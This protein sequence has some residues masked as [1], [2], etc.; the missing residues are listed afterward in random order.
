MLE[1]AGAIPP[2]AFYGRIV[3]SRCPVRSGTTSSRPPDQRTHSA[4][5]QQQQTAARVIA[6]RGEVGREEVLR[7]KKIFF[8]VTVEIGDTGVERGRQLRLGR[9]RVGVEMV[10]SIQEDHVV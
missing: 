3:M 2:S 10:A 9:E 4:V 8:A 6:R 7:Q 1:R 5:A